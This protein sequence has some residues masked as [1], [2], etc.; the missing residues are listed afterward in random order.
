MRHLIIAFALIASV[1][2]TKS[3]AAEK[4]ISPIVMETFHH[5][6]KDAKNVTWEDINGLIRVN[7]TSEDKE[8]YA[9]YNNDGELLVL[10]KSISL[11][12][13]PNGLQAGLKNKYA[14]YTVINIYKLESDDHNEFCV[15]LSK[16]NKMLTLNGTFKKWRTVL[17]E[18][19]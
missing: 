2:T 9:Y 18:K 15:V 8:S 3:F 7:F 19:K 13:L 10:A 5:S 17:N 1:Y 16:D 14:D 11:S 4:N 12:E 6:F